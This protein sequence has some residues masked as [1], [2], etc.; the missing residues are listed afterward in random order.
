MSRN[1]QERLTPELLAKAAS[2]FG[3]QPGQLRPAGGYQ[4]I[5]YECERGILRLSHASHR[6]SAMVAAELDWV[7]FLAEHGVPV[8]RPISSHNSTLAEPA[9]EFTA[10]LFEKAGG[11]QPGH[12]EA[13][14]AVGRITGRMHALARRYRPPAG[15]ARRFEWHENSYL[16]GIKLYIPGAETRVHETIAR[17]LRTI[18]DLPR[19]DDAYGLIHGDIWPGNY[20]IDESG[21]VTL[22]DFDE[23]QHGWFASDIGIMLFYVSAFPDQ[24]THEDVSRF[25]AE[26]LDGYSQEHTLDPFWVRQL[27]LFVRLRQIILYAEL[28]RISGQDSRPLHPWRQALFSHARHTLEHD[29]PPID[30]SFG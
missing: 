23:C 6:S 8:S 7:R 22:F 18:A 17:T 4:N 28:H 25:M 2:R 19:A 14:R 1:M 30:F 12:V 27:P 15:I 20:R 16:E 11:H 10:A 13:L 5:V 29:L 24:T 3:L 21:A 9:G 26:F